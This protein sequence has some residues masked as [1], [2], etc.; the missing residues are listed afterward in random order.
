[1]AADLS[2]TIAGPAS[3]TAGQIEAWYTGQGHGQGNLTAPLASVIGWYLGAGTAAG[4][5]GDVAFAQACLETGY[6]TSPDTA[7]NNFA[8]IGHPVGAPSGLDF[9]TAEV[10][11]ASQI[12]ELYKVVNSNA[13]VCSGLAAF[14]LSG[15]NDGITSYYR[16]TTTWN[17]L[18][19]NWAADTS[20]GQKIIEIYNSMLG[21]NSLASA[22][23][24]TAPSY[25]PGV[26]NPAGVGTL[27]TINK[28]ARAPRQ[29]TSLT[30]QWPH[31]GTP[32]RMPAAD[33]LAASVTTDSTVD[34]SYDQ[35]SQIQ[36]T[37]ADPT[38]VFSQIGDGINQHGGVGPQLLWGAQPMTVSE[39]QTLDT[40]SIPST[41]LTLRTSCL[42]WM[43]T[44]R[45][46][47]NWE[48]I[49]ATAWIGACVA[50]YNS[51]LGA[52]VPPATFLG[53]FSQPRPQ[54]MANPGEAI[55][56][57]MSYYDIAQQLC[58]EEGFWLFETDNVVVFGKPTWLGTFAPS[59][60]IGW[61]GLEGNRL[62]PPVLPNV[63]VRAL[64]FPRCL[65]SDQLF[66]GDTVQVDLPHDFG[67]QVRVGQQFQL[68]GVGTFWRNP[69][70]VTQVQF[71]YDGHATPVTIGG[72]QVKDPV[73]A[74]PGGVAP[75]PPQSDPTGNPPT[76]T[77][78]QFV[79]TALSQVGVPYVWGGTTPTTGF[80]CSGLV[81]W[82][83]GQLGVTFPHYSGSQ[84]QVI[85]QAGDQISIAQAYRTRGALLFLDAGSVPG[86]EHVAISMGDGTNVLQAPYPGVDVQVDAVPQSYWSRAGIIP[87]LNYGP[88]N[89]SNG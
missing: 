60:V 20:Y 18:S 61:E 73:P 6:F 31:A 53:D 83:L 12:A 48:G 49:S 8:G 68:S 88:N 56:F 41:V 84:W 67:E 50:E 4:I 13:A 24:Q 44:R 14:G 29:V 5:R 28:Q 76:A 1:M 3:L 45:V 55:T 11:V 7:L 58:Y 82:A 66:T 26:T 86:G 22:T 54:I 43:A 21:G 89:G 42:E 79:D 9:A 81:M 19:G 39:I 78:L 23:S 69:Y 36:L 71:N 70:I 47:R 15:G 80:D 77:N 52:G 27:P 35:L 75:A 85:A 34:L 64:T 74:A 87:Y 46:R 2:L 63:D 30:F 59:F 32:A 33:M 40:N 10:G 65:R 37:L 57:W 17:G 16:Q 51:L 38:A 62:V 72:N 25:S